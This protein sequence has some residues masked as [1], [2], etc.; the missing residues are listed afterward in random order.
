MYL[1]H[2]KILALLHLHVE[3]TLE[4]L[5]PSVLPFTVGF[6]YGILPAMNKQNNKF[7]ERKTL[8]PH[9]SRNVATQFSV[10]MI[11]VV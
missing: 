11:E 10:F 5:V 2:P 7:C 8:L 1:L 9:E 3:Q 6:A 4:D